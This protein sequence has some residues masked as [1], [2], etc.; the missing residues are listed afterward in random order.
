MEEQTQTHTHTH[1]NVYKNV[2]LFSCELASR[3]DIGWGW[4][5]QRVFVSASGFVSFGGF[6][7]FEYMI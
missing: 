6:V 2:I 5:E 1:N 7:C 3:I 4:N